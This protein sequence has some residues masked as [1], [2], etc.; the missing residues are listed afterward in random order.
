MTVLLRGHLAVVEAVGVL[1]ERRERRVHAEVD[2]ALGVGLDN[3]IEAV[4]QPLRPETRLQAA[5]ASS[6]AVSL[7]CTRR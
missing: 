4:S 2:E 6:L 1:D 5:K 7:T 3:C